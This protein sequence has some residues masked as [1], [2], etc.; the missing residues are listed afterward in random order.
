M[1]LDGLLAFFGILIGI[2]AIADPIQ[3]R[4]L[5]LF[6][7][8][9]WLV[10]A[11]FLS[12]VFILIPSAAEIWWYPLSPFTLFILR[13]L[14]F[15]IP[16]V[17]VLVC[18][19]FWKRAHLTDRNKGRLTDVLKASLRESRFDEVEKIL[20]QNQDRLPKLPADALTVLFDRQ[21]VRALLRARS[22]LHL[23][24]LADVGFLKSLGNRFDAIDVVVRELLRAET[25]PLRSVVLWSCGG[26]EWH[27]YTAEEKTVVQKTFLN[28]EWYSEASAHYPLIMAAQEELLSGKLDV[29]YNQIGRNY[30]ATQGI[31]T[32]S[33]CIIFLAVKTHVLA[34]GEAIKRRVE[35]DFYVTDLY[36]TFL[37]ILERSRYQPDMWE[38]TSGNYEHPT[39]YAYLLREIVN[40]LWNLS[41]EA[42]QAATRKNSITLAQQLQMVCRTLEEREGRDHSVENAL[43]C[44]S[45]RPCCATARSILVILCLGHCSIR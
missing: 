20:K 29:E 27:S 18:R 28:P 17:A 1:T 13:V 42:L 44:S 7:P 14:S 15:A 26:H 41:C 3:R 19:V 45:A 36:Q 8:F 35:R 16:V 25:S 6:V 23:E 39:P 24:L 38:S 37:A 4:S 9:R 40:D 34:I 11:L 33:H 12:L 30:E 31:S 22:F 5:L 10:G 2:Y 32:R 43:G 21:M